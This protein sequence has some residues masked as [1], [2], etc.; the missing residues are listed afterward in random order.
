MIQHAEELLEI[1]DWTGLEI[2]FHPIR[3]DRFKGLLEEALRA[4]E[5][6]QADRYWS[7]NNRMK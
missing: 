4:P 5:S 2:E 1:F 6:R 3:L 7:D